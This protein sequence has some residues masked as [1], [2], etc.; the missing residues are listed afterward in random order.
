M[1]HVLGPGFVAYGGNSR[2]S[3]GG[4]GLNNADRRPVKLLP[5][6]PAKPNSTLLASRNWGCI[7]EILSSRPGSESNRRPI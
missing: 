6:E 2:N 3:S 7:N 4:T 5:V 1:R